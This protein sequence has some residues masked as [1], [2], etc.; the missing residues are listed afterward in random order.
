MAKKNIDWENLSF[1]YIKTDKRYVSNYTN[2]AWD[3]GAL[4]DDDMITMSECACVLQYSQ[5]IFEGLK[6]YTTEKG[7]IVI[8]PN[9]DPGEYT[10]KY[11][12]ITMPT[13]TT[14]STTSTTTTTTAGS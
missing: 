3:E 10:A 5:T 13:N 6:A 7:Q 12:V 8:D 1:G 14:V 2:G 4:I 11:V 9:V